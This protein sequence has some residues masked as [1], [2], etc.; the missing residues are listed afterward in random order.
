M[1]F[2]LAGVYAH[3]QYLYC[4]L[5]FCENWTPQKFPTILY[6]YIYSKLHAIKE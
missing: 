3:Q 6:I 4:E 2:I 1:A 5:V